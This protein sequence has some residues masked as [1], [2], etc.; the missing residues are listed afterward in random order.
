MAET[1]MKLNLV[2]DKDMSKKISSVYF[3]FIVFEK[4]KFLRSDKKNL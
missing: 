4:K 2:I 1:K 3:I